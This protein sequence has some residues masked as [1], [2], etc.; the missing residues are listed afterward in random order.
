MRLFLAFLA[1]VVPGVASTGIGGHRQGGASGYSVSAIHWQ[2]DALG[3]V[4]AVSFRL[5]PANARSV[6]VSL[7]D[8]GWLRCAVAGGRATCAVPGGAPAA[9]LEHLSVVASS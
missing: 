8:G 6:H 4:G 3:R 1:V 2:L 7:R 5:A 9:A